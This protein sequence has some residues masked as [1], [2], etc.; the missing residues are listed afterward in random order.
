MPI[1][2]VTT[3]PNQSDEKCRELVE[4]L[5]LTV[6]RVTGAPF[7]KI[8]VYIQ[9]IAQNR[10]GEGGVLGTDPGFAELSRRRTRPAAAPGTAAGTGTDTVA[11]V[12]PGAPG[13]AAGAAAAGA[14]AGAGAVSA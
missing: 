4:E 1:V 7:D 11:P 3:W 13:A 14:G 10:W 5:T 12:S 9:E 2:N 8:T 6:N